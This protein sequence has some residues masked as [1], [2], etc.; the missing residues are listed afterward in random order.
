MCL[1]L[2]YSA[3]LTQLGTNTHGGNLAILD[4]IVQAVSARQGN[5]VHPSFYGFSSF[6]T[7]IPSAHP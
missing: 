1:Y 6:H 5:A 3:P 4:F 2:A 7:A